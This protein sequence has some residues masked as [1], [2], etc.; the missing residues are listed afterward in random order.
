MARVLIADDDED[1]RAML[2]LVLENAGYEVHA[3]S[4]G[5][6]AIRA[7]GQHPAD[8]LITDLFMPVRDGLETVDYFR[9]RYPGM[10]IIAISGGG[11]T[12]QKTDYLAV[13]QHAGADAVFRKPFDVGQL[14]E[15]VRSL[16]PK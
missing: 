11:Y 5:E 3:V 9:S 15:R 12:G 1:L 6:Q 2:K 4:D 13:A 14:L 8:L 10:R 7:H 16:T